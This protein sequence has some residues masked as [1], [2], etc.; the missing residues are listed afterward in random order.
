MRDS[1]E[2]VPILIM[3]RE[4]AIHAWLSHQLAGCAY[5]LAPASSDASFRRYWR[6]V[7][8]DG[9]SAILMDAP[10]AHEDI[11]PWLRV[12]KEFAAA[13]LKVPEVFAHDVEQGFVLLADF[14]DRTYLAALAAGE[15]AD[16][17]YREALAALVRLQLASRPGVLPE[18]DRRLLLTELELFP[19]WYLGRHLGLA[20]SAEERNLL[21]RLF[22]T[23][24]AVNLGEPKVFVH[25]DYHTR[26]L[27]PIAEGPGVI[28][29][30]DAVY[31]P[32]SYDLVS[33]LKDAYVAWDEEI[34]LDWLIR[35]WE[36]AKKAGL[37]VD[38]D[39]GAFYRA[40]EWMGVQRHLKVLGIFA[41]LKHR[42]GKEAY[43]A[44]MPRVFAYL[45]VT[46][47]RYGALAPLAQL[48]DRIADRQPQFAYTF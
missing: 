33:L 45:S 48:L 26:N 5:T 14:G 16:R 23:I 35:Y 25:R 20:L 17:L 3:P 10:P 31:G 39:F 12:Q 1:S 28:D 2:P 27:M 46:C 22:E 41:R 37:P 18:Y 47:R 8:A 44:D 43:L 15:D 11:R 9:E 13:G 21:A 6:V 34:T 29:F 7:R 19:E 24:L 4:E 30:Q 32:L 38:P 42:D 40:Y 36:Q